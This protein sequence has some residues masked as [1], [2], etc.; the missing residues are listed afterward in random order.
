M[1]LPI[2]EPRPPAR[3]GNLAGGGWQAYIPKDVDLSKWEA[4]TK[5]FR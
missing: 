5:P 4:W 1:Y 3:Q 2:F